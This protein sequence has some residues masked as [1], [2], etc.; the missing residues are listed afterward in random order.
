MTRLASRGI[1]AGCIMMAVVAN[2][3]AQ[4]AAGWKWN[5]LYPGKNSCNGHPMGSVWYGPETDVCGRPMKHR[6]VPI[7]TPFPP[8][9]PCNSAAAAR[10][11]RNDQLR[12]APVLTRLQAI[13]QQAP[14]DAEALERKSPRVIRFCRTVTTFI[15]NLTEENMIGARSHVN[16]WLKD[17]PNYS[18][19]MGIRG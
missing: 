10:M 19:C 1:I 14:Y 9:I 16:G 15:G 3:S 4:Q 5:A 12:G 18:F 2:A 17:H 13:L 11:N 8:P 6:C 7:G